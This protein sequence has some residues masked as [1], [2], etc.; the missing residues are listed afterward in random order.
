M[1]QE[2]HK[3]VGRVLGYWK[4]WDALTHVVVREAGHMVPRDDP[5]TSQVTFPYPLFK[6]Y[7]ECSWMLC[8]R[9]GV[10]LL[11]F[12]MGTWGPFPGEGDTE[13]L[14]TCEKQKDTPGTPLPVSL[15]WLECCHKE[16]WIL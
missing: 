12:H 1:L 9:F 2:D 3:G 10:G 13:K 16:L 11:V 14:Y 15:S 6:L 7:G 5:I 4:E 8:G